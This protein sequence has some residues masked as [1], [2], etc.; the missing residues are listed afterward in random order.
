MSKKP[1]A[2]PQSVTVL[3]PDDLA[4]ILAQLEAHAAQLADHESRLLELEVV[5]PESPEPPD[6]TAPDKALWEA[7]MI[8]YGMQHG[9]YFDTQPEPTNDQKLDHV[10]YDGCRVYA[11]IAAYTGNA[12]PWT[13]YAKKAMEWFYDYAI[14]RNA[15]AVPGYYNFTHGLRMDYERT[16]DERSK[17]GVITL[18]HKAGYAQ[19]S[20]NRDW[21]KPFN[22]SREVA[23]AITS[24]INAEALGEAKR[25]QRA[26]WVTFAYDHCRQWMDQSTW[27]T[28]QIAPFM[29][30]ITAESL[31]EDWEETQDT[32][33]LPTLKAMVD[34]MWPLAWFE[35]NS[36]LLYQFNPAHPDGASTTGA[37]DLNM[38]IA[39]WLS[40]LWVQTGEDLYRER[41]DALLY[42]HKDA[43]LTR[44]K[45]FNQNYWVAFNGMRWREGGAL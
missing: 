41:F 16:G 33:C 38:L 36:G 42:G 19:D 43:Y 32:R 28:E 8:E 37:V 26:E 44:S 9:S 20:C 17:Q 23:Y 25:G 13:G 35:G 22:R 29:M 11:Q 7:H 27:G 14:T 1:E 18:S 12:E 21:V 39:P 30:A 31:I 15:G 5:D 4:P 45:Q 6:A 3:T 2:T 24:Y 40:W 10:Y 34:W